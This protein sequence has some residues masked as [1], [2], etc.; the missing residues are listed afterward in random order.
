[1][2]SK[3]DKEISKLKLQ[4]LQ[5]LD[6]YDSDSLGFAFHTILSWLRYPELQASEGYNHGIIFSVLKAMG[7]AV[8][9]QK[10]ASQG[11]FDI[12]LTVDNKVVFVCEC[13]YTKFNPDEHLSEEEKNSKLNELLDKTLKLAIDQ[14]TFRDYSNEFTDKYEVVKKIAIAFVGNDYVKLLI[15]P[16]KNNQILESNLQKT[17]IIKE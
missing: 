11:L 12:L 10:T 3:G 9:S 15:Y 2:L 13:K 5:A 6:K 7:L 17:L 8:D 16:E 4:I 1:L 14:I